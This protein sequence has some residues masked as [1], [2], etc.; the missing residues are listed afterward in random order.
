VVGSATGLR[1]Q[2]R[3]AAYSAARAAQH[4]YLR[5]VGAEVAAFKMDIGLPNTVALMIRGE[6]NGNEILRLPRLI[7]SA[8]SVN[9][10]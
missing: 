4:G 9:R 1:G 2:P 6:F 5:S 10:L 3:R 7:V 8:S